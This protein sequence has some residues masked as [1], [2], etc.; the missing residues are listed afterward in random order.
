LKFCG[1][2]PR[3]GSG[4]GSLTRCCWMLL[5]DSAAESMPLVDHEAAAAVKLAHGAAKRRGYIWSS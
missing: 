4:A 1:I 2:A 5:L 3:A